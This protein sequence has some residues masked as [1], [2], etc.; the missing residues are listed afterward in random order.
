MTRQEAQDRSKTQP[1]EFK[2]L[3][4]GGAQDEEAWAQ[5]FE[6]IEWVAEGQPDVMDQEPGEED[7]RYEADEADEAELQEEDA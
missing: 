7:K 5:W 6:Y 1:T 2:A 3:G 4:S